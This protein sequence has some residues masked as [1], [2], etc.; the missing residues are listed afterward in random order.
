MSRY[1][2]ILAA[3]CAAMTLALPDR[4]T[5]DQDPPGCTQ[6][7]N[8]AGLGNAQGAVIHG[9]IICYIV[10]FSNASAPGVLNC[11]LTLMTTDLELPDGSIVNVT[12]NADLPAEQGFFC[13][14]GDHRCVTPGDAECA[15][16]GYKYEVLHN[17][18][19]ESFSGCVNI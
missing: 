2:A 9:D 10:S 3:V 17:D 1:P 8:P 18:E 7:A 12:L 4:A 11:D 16:N 13:P 5:G 14:S 6:A 19:V 15:G